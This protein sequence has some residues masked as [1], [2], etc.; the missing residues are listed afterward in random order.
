[1]SVVKGP[2]AIV[3]GVTPDSIAHQLGIEVGDKVVEVN[4]HVLVDNLDLQFAAN[5]SELTLLVERAGERTL[6]EIEKDEEDELG[7]EFEDET[8]DGIR[9][10]KNNC[11]FCF[12]YQ[13]PRGL[14]KSLY[15]KDEDFRYS[16]MYGNYMTLTN[17]EQ[18]EMQRIVDQRLSPIYVSVHATDQKVRDMLLGRPNTPPLGP[19]LDFLTKHGIEFYAQLVLCPGINDGAVLEQTLKDL[20][21]YFPRLRGITGVPVGLTRYRDFLFELRPYEQAGAREMIQYT[22]EKQRDYFKRLGTRLFYLADEFYL[23]AKQPFPPPEDYERFETREDGV[24]LIPR[25]VHNTKKALKR[26][27]RLP[28]KD[29][30]VI[31]VTGRAGEGMFRDEVIPAMTAAGWPKPLLYPITNQ[32][33]GPTITVAGLLTGR[34]L[35]AGLKFAPKVDAVLVCD[36]ALKTGTD[37]FLD[38]LTVADLERELGQ[39]ILPVT[40]S[41]NDLLQT[42]RDVKPSAHRRNRSGW[43]AEV[44]RD[45]QDRFHPPLDPDPGKLIPLFNKPAAIWPKGG[46][47]GGE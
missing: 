37:M 38:D 42:I 25:F 23:I 26:F 35:Q 21:P 4:G 33:F 20:E 31:I 32:F 18:H 27:K 39:R 29:R 45:G 19:R 47:S 8:F 1:M 12:V 40:D 17:L 15:I 41:P 24:G 28:P 3:T 36:Y 9:R 10:C 16:F 2:Q 11:V 44:K 22:L 7:L 43:E 5:A 6:F 30:K 34:D 13:N 14:R 46:C